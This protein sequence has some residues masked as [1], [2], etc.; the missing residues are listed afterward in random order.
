MT[1]TTELNRGDAIQGVDLPTDHDESIREEE[2]HS[3]PYQRWIL[4]AFSMAC[5]S[6]VSG[7]IY[8]WPAL[9][10]QLQDDGS[11]LTEEQLGAI[12]TVAAWSAQ[13]GRIF[14]GLARDRFGTRTVVCASLCCSLIGAVGI[15]LADASNA[16]A[17]GV[18]LFV[19][20]LSAGVMLVQSVG[21][22]FPKISNAIITSISGGFHVSGLV[23]LVLTSLPSTRRASFLGYAVVVSGMLVLAWILLPVTPTFSHS[24]AQQQQEPKDPKDAG[25]LEDRSGFTEEESE[26][27]SDIEEGRKKLARNV[28]P[29]KAQQVFSAE[30]LMLLVWFS[31]CFLPCNYYV[32]TLGFQ[33]EQIGDEDGYYANLFTFIYAAASIAAPAGGYMSDKLGFGITQGLATIMLSFSFTIFGAAEYLP[34]PAQISSFVLYSVGRML[35]SG[36]FYSNIGRRF[37]Y[38]NFGTLSGMGLLVAATFS[39]LQYPLI[40]VASAGSASIVNFTA[41]AVLLLT[42]TPYCAWL[43]ATERRDEFAVSLLRRKEKVQKTEILPEEEIIF[44]C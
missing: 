41:G 32:G 19:M 16:L 44:D 26:S 37:G 7:V 5:T 36:M 24:A 2:H 30:Y 22:L 18:S 28:I 1:L 29:T 6:L 14:P 21:A 42:M 3:R 23:F 40:A 17:L 4:F 11:T 27:E 34:L 31:F 38:T 33:L 13:G 10:R 25:F 8:G 12:Y 43:A 9:R 15:A 35:V 20:S 39:L